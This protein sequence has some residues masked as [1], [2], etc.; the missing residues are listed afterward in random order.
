MSEIVLK[1]AA[2]GLHPSPLPLG[3]LRPGEPDGC[4]LCTTCNS[5]ACRIHAK[6]DA[7]VCGIRPA[8]QQP[9]VTLWTNACAQRLVTDPSGQRIVA[10]EVVRNGESVRVEAPLF[11][12]S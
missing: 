5:F 9:N 10:A 8:L 1:L 2:Q 3:L 11:I 12:V 6:S 4:I 7:E